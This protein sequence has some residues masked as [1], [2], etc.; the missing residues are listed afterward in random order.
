MIIQ[1]TNKYTIFSNIVIVSL[2]D[3]IQIQFSKLIVKASY[4]DIEINNFYQKSSE[5]NQ[6]FIFKRRFF[7]K[8]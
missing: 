5:S 4:I 3:E 2:K 1:K 7:I 6:N 8:K